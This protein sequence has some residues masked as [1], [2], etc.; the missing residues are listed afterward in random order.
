MKKLIIPTLA[1]TVEQN[2]AFA[3]PGTA[4]GPTALALA[5]VIAQHSPAVRTFDKRVIARLFRGNTSFGFTPNTKI[6]V[7]ADSLVCRVSNVDITSRSCDLSFGARKR[8][9]TG[10]EANEVGATAAAAGVPSQGAAGSSIESGSNLRCTMDPNEIMRKAGGGA[11]CTFE[12][13]Q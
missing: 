7:D 1:L 5:A 2:T 10:R 11:D 13:G 9:L 12:T 4:T 3:A 8:K 6:S